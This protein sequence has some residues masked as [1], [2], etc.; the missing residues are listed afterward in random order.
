MEAGKE[1]VTLE[2]QEPIGVGHSQACGQ[3]L[4][5]KVVALP[6]VAPWC[7][8]IAGLPNFNL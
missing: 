6:A 4:Y 8:R 1:D 3:L 5:Y 2:L 7:P